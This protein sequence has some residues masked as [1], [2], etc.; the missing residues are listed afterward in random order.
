MPYAEATNNR[1]IPILGVSAFIEHEGK[2]L[3]V[4]RGQAPNKEQLAFPGGKV[5]WG[6][7]LIEAVERELKEETAL[8]GQ[9][10]E[11]LHAVNIIMPDAQ[12]QT[13]RH[14]V[15]LCYRCRWLGG[16]AQAGDDASQILWLSGPQLLKH[17]DSTDGVREVLQKLYSI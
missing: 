17:P 14:F 8:T 13:S 10:E 4:R 16:T 1:H 3:V 15:V 12:G 11:L 6:E 2:I 7:T 9:A 5:Q